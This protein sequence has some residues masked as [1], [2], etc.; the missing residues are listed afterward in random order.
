M[1]ALD[2]VLHRLLARE[3]PVAQAYRPSFFKLPADQQALR[4]LLEQE[5]AIHVHDRMHAQL[6]ELL[7]SLH[8]SV[9]FTSE[10]LELAIADHLSGKTMTEYGQWVFYPWSKTLVHLLEAEEFAQ[11]RTDRNRNKIT[12]EEQLVLAGKKIGVIGLSVGQSVSLTMALERCFG[13]IRLADF[14]TLDLSNLNRIR[15]GVANLGVNKAVVTAREIAEIDPY[16]NVVCFTDG[17]TRANL[18]DYFTSGGKLDILVEECD[19]VDIKILARQK[20]KEL[21]IPVVMD[22]SDRGCLDVERFDLEPER[23]ILHGWIDHLD[24]EAAKRPMSAEEKVPYMLPIT[25]VET[26]SPRMKASVIELGQ[27][28]STWPQLATSVVLGGALAGDAVRRIALDQFRSSGRWHVDLEQQIADI[29][30]VVP[31]VPLP[32]DHSALGLLPD[33]LEPLLGAVPGEALALD[34]PAMNA[35]EQAATLAPSE[36]NL[37]PWKLHWHG[38]RLLLLH[39]SERSRSVWDP[40]H[41]LAQLALGACLENIVL[42]AHEL[43]LEAIPGPEVLELPQLAA[44]LVFAASGTPGGAAGD[45]DHL[46]DA[47]AQHHTYRGPGTKQELPVAD[48]QRLEHAAGSF[49]ARVHWLEGE[50]HMQLLA[51]LLA[52]TER[53]RMMHPEGHREFF[54]QWLS[55]NDPDHVAENSG[56]PLRDLALPPMAEAALK[57]MADPK[58]MD[59]LRQWDGGKTIGMLPIL[60]LGSSSAVA[61]ITLASGV[62]QPG[63]LAAGRAVQRLWLS[64]RQ[65]GWGVQPIVSPILL[66]VAVAASPGRFS[67]QVHETAALVQTGLQDLFG[68]GPGTPLCL[69]RI[70]K[71][72]G[73]AAHAQPAIRQLLQQ[74][75]QT[76]HA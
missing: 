8:P 37:R 4:Q 24:L 18:D 40:D 72:V 68:T 60:H 10:E 30:E 31:P 62:D 17:L 12:R 13:E 74:P 5:P 3:Q 45:W 50:Q 64:A 66:P 16:L 38:R 35:L 63:G 53:I 15:T 2:P 26:L 22:M 41:R 55:W 70:S 11:V 42:K 23:P 69:L 46:A 34:A 36:G 48:R 32:G 49:H 71:P 27:T 75:S 56:V 39:D 21:G 6:Q 44:S 47:I 7:K 20:A 76:L 73:H 25:G 67:R 65:L 61:L 29:P 43:G 28:I 51:G 33:V 1:M 19:S 57:V 54:T 9:K 52:Q 58:A 14:D 59:L